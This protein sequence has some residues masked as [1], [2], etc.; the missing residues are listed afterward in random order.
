V[1]NRGTGSRARLEG[2]KRPAAGKT[3]TTDDYADAWF[4]GYT[5]DL[6]AGVWFGHDEN[7]T[8]MRRGFAA[9]VAVPAWAR[10]MVMAT[11]ETKPRWFDM[12]S[13][14]ERLTIC[15]KSGLRAATAC[16]VVFSEDGRSNIFD[17]LFMRGTAPYE[18]CSG[19]HTD[20][21]NADTATTAPP[22][23]TALSAVS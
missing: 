19:D 9:T 6:V 16:R 4:V 17:E 15:R 14:V 23:M 5:P 7:K 20:P 11:K 1:M 18:T 13:D 3:G 10:F 22:P 8:I 2:F 21:P 12:P